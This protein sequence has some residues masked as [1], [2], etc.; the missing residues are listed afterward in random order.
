MEIFP[1]HVDHSIPAAYAFLFCTSA[2]LVVYSGDFRMHGPLSHMT[3]DFLNKVKEL[4]KEKGRVLALICEGTFI[5]KGSIE[6]E[7][8]VE[9]Q[10]EELFKDNPF[11]YFIVKHNSAD[12]D[13]F[14]TFATIAKDQNWNYIIQEKDA[15]F[16]H[17]LNQDP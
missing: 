10:L 4:S 15:Y 8:R 6:S 1:V 3:T 2:G 17:I 9:N 14:R 5:Q 16:Y 7:D 13:R 12:W 11:E